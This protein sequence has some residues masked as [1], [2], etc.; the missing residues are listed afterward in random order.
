MDKTERDAAIE[1]RRGKLLESYDAYIQR[2]EE[3]AAT[4]GMD[5]DV[6]TDIAPGLLDQ[7]HEAQTALSLLNLLYNNIGAGHRFIAIARADIGP[8]PGV[9]TTGVGRHTQ[10]ALSTYVRVFEN[11]QA[12]QVKYIKGQDGDSRVAIVAPHY[13]LQVHDENRLTVTTEEEVNILV[14]ARP[15]YSTNMPHVPELLIAKTEVYGGDTES[16]AFRSIDQ[17][18]VTELSPGIG[19]E[20]N[21]WVIQ[22]K[23]RKS[24]PAPE[25]D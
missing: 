5:L 10:V 24:A 23:R 15:A 21:D 19:L 17:L 8:D 25:S 7:S 11:L 16:V 4:T 12:G 9:R 2:L 3:M 1:K 20:I 14:Q 22:T 13:F 6:M 18:G